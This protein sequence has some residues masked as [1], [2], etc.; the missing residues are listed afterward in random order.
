MSDAHDE[1]AIYACDVCGQLSVPRHPVSWY[2]AR[3][4]FPHCLRIISV[5]G[6]HS[7]APAGAN[8]CKGT[9]RRFGWLTQIDPSHPLLPQGLA[10]RPPEPEQ[11]E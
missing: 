4:G 7:G 11:A 3:E 2:V 10:S 9:L 1:F 8:Y 5:D 6:G